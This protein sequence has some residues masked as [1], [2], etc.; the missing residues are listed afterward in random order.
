MVSEL[1]Q[2]GSCVTL[3]AVGTC[4]QDSKFVLLFMSPQMIATV[5]RVLIFKFTNKL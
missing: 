1:N 4:G 2:E 3:S 5:P